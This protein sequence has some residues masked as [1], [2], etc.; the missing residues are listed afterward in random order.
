[1]NIMD[2]LRDK[3]REGTKN[4]VDFKIYAGGVQGDESDVLRKIR[5][6]QLHG[7][8]FVGFALG[9]IAPEVR[10][11]EIM[12][13]FRNHEEVAY[14][15]GKLEETMTKYF[16]DRGYV[17]LGWTDAG[18]VY[19]F[20]KEPLTSI[21]VLK[22]QKCWV[23]GDDPVM[24]SFY[25]AVGVQPIPLSITD[26]MT[27]LSAGLIDNVFNTPFGIIALRWHTKFR[28]MTDI[29]V[30]NGVGALV[31]RK[32][33]WNKVSPGS[34]KKIK[35]IAKIQFKRL[36]RD[37]IEADKKSLGILKKAGIK[38]APFLNS[39]TDRGP[40]LEIG[41]KARES[42]IGKLYSRELL[43]RTLAL[44]REYRQNHPNSSFIR[45]R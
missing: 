37:I 44:L 8:I 2:D 38:I 32:E 4:E 6:K 19:M 9:R 26:V 24:I 21:E 5:M 14:V 20:S 12:F 15:R 27:S 42:L 45:I 41:K 17:V 35:E 23:W 31:V 43:E 40:L 10:V 29:P 25:K 33:I 13:A 7:G 3:V 16:G 28:Y 39:A 30:G 36:T 18:F 1:M 11:T 34:Q 22:R